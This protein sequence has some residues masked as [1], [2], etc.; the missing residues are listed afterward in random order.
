MWKGTA[1]VTAKNTVPTI[2]WFRNG[3][4]INQHFSKSQFLI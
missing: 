2:E 1:K 4:V 3:R